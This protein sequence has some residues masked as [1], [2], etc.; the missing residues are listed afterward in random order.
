ACLL[1]TSDLTASPGRAGGEAVATRVADCRKPDIGPAG[2]VA[3]AI[4]LSGSRVGRHISPPSWDSGCTK[5]R[6]SLPILF[7]ERPCA[8]GSWLPVA[9]AAKTNSRIVRH[10]RT[11]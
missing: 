6:R 7:V 2:I 8:K 9:S 3:A 5:T 11:A 1:A 4:R 10:L